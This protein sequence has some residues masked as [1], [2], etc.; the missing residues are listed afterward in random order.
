LKLA[1]L[2]DISELYKIL[3]SLTQKPKIYIKLLTGKTIA[4]SCLFNSTIQNIKD[5]IKDME[6]IPT[7]KQILY[8]K[9]KQLE[10][11]GKPVTVEQKKPQK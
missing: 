1:T 11:N 5:K 10:N 7:E 8:L 3:S 9:K 4:I 6:G 2:L